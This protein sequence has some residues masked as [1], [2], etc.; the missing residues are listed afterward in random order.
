MII[1]NAT[2]GQ[3][4]MALNRVGDM[5]KDNLAFNRLDQQG[6]SYR[7]TLRVND[8]KGVGAGRG[9][10]QMHYISGKSYDWAW[11]HRRKLVSACW[12]VHGDFFE[13]LFRLCPRAVVISRGNKITA[14][15]GNWKDFDMGSIMCLYPASK[16]CEC[17]KDWG[18]L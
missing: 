11:E 8:S 6:N 13:V 1:R 12:H 14:Q 9:S 10:Y 18:G 3:I 16:A 17:K 7:V 4:V 5:Y 15:G 2:K